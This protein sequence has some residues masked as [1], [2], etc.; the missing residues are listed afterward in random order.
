VR[1]ITPA[2]NIG[3][4]DPD[5]DEKADISEGI[6][7]FDSKG[8]LVDIRICVQGCVTLQYFK[9]KLTKLCTNPYR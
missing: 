7:N 1:K 9:T 5:E 3:N 8:N 6:V 4:S 2:T